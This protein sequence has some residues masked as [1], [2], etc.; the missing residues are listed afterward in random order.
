MQRVDQFYGNRI[1]MTPI[2]CM[3]LLQYI[4]INTIGSSR[5]V[6][7]SQLN[8]MACRKEET[9]GEVNIL[10]NERWTTN[11]IHINSSNYFDDSI[12]RS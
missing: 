8:C 4:D 12:H 11:L 10:R 2:E 7:T 6:R 9:E 1:E 3:C 5:Y